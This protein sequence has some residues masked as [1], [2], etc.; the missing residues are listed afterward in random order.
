MT[1]LTIVA[2]TTV[3]L[4]FIAII[5]SEKTVIITVT[6]LINRTDASVLA[7]HSIC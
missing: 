5:F 3:V 6:V 4:M 2:A 1:T 7:C